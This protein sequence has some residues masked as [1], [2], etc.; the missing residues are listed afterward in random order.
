MPKAVSRPPADEE[1][2][3]TAPSR[4]ATNTKARSSGTSPWSPASNTLK[5]SPAAR[6]CVMR[7]AHDLCSV[8]GVGEDECGAR[9][10]V[11]HE[12]SAWGV[13]VWRPGCRQGLVSSRPVRHGSVGVDEHPR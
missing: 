13:A 11:G 5:A 12:F 9:I 6:A 8:Q 1:A 2:G 3:M 10:G 4:K 7:I